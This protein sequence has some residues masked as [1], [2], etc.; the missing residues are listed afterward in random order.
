MS[1]R[2]LIEFLISVYLKKLLDKGLPEWFVGSLLDWY[3]KCTAVVRWGNS[4]ST[5]FAIK[6]GV[7]QGG[8]LSPILFALYI[9][10]IATSLSSAKLGCMINGV[11][12]GCLLYAD[13]IIL[14]SCSNC[15]LQSMLDLCCDIIRKIDLNFN[16]K[17][18]VL[19]RIGPRW[20]RSCSNLF[21][22]GNPLL[23]V[24]E[25]KYLGIVFKSGPLFSYN[26]DTAKAKFYRSFNAVFNRSKYA[27]SELISV[28][29][30][31]TYCL[32]LI[33]MNFKTVWN[34]YINF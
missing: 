31:K 5:P 33:A 26:I 25:I 6:A 16:V 8:V 18:S 34:P 28:H 23:F 27:N 22:D 4:F 29:L 20:K 2:R 9:D 1:P 19:I 11:Y 15:R 14:L 24:T 3:S 13:D 30:F 21:I 17:K 32:P 10:D 7:R 12:V